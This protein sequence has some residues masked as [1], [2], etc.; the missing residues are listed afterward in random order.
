VNPP[1]ALDPRDRRPLYVQIADG[2]VAAIERGSLLPDARLPAMRTLASQLGCALITVSQAYEM[3]AARGRVVAR[4]GRG[5]FI[6]RPPAPAETAFARK[7]EPD[8]GRVARA[9]RRA[10]STDARGRA[11]CDFACDRTPR[12]GNISARGVWARDAAHARR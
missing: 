5:T 9:E 11:G 4:V 7:W 1:L 8:L 10:R 12:T 2:I 6:A 3:L